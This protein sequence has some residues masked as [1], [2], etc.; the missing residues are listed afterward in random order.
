MK[1]SV[2]AWLAQR[3]ADWVSADTAGRLRMQVK[4]KTPA[5]RAAATSEDMPELESSGE[6]A[7]E[8]E[9]MPRTPT[10][11]DFLPSRVVVGPELLEHVDQIQEKGSLRKALKEMPFWKPA[12]VDVAPRQMAKVSK[13]VQSRVLPKQQHPFRKRSRFDY[14]DEDELQEEERSSKRVREETDLSPEDQ[15]IALFHPDNKTIRDRLHANNAFR[16]PSEFQMPGT[17]FY[18]YRNG[19]QWVW[20]DD[21]KLRKLAKDYSF[22]W[23]LIAEEMTLPS[24]FKS[25]MERRTPWECFERWVELEQLPAEMRKTVYFKTWFQRL[26]Q[27]QQAVDRRYSAQV[28]AVQQAQQ[29]SNGGQQQH[30]PM[31]RRTMPT[32]V[33]KRKTT[34]YLWVVDAMRKLARKREGAAFK[35]AEGKFSRESVNA[36]ANVIQLNVR[37]LSAS[38]PPS[39]TRQTNLL[40]VRS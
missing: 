12:E 23:S 4:V 22:N 33:E 40:V 36:I 9:G 30:L 18:E 8:D 25:G 1:K 15:D 31:K 13:F 27:S 10:S 5:P 24:Q 6:S 28:A 11:N 17:P 19:S 37:Q 38:L 16:P 14:E 32:R 3:C 34:R 2:C 7:P 21:Q 35:Q 20:E 26:D 39:K 29:N